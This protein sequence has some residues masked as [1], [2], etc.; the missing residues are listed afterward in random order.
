MGKHFKDKE[1]EREWE[2]YEK[3]KETFDKE[4][5][6]NIFKREIEKNKND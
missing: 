4:Q 2:K 3:Y 1:L 5:L 6:N